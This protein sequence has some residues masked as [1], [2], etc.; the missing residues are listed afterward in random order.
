MSTGLS[1]T[2]MPSYRD[3]LSERIAGSRLLRRLAVLFQGP[4]HREPLPIFRSG[5]GGA[6][7]SQAGGWHPDD[8]YVRGGTCIAPPHPARRWP[9][10]P[11]KE[12]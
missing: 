6:Q 7:R 11:R 10:G 4:A 8:A 3:S 5:P 1:G 2:P 9:A 12:E